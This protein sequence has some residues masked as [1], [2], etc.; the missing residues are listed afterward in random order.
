ML[1]A[2]S[3]APAQK[4][5]AGMM[6]RAKAPPMML[7]KY[8][9]PALRANFIRPPAGAGVVWPDSIPLV[10]GFVAIMMWR[11]FLLDGVIG[12]MTVW[13]VRFDLEPPRLRGRA[14]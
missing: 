9:T 2:I 6:L 13:E 3:A 7:I 1:C 10:V 12:T 5:K 11:S 8:R 4:N 14:A